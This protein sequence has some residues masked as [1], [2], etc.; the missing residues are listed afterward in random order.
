MLAKEGGLPDVS[1]FVSGAFK[2]IHISVFCKSFGE[3]T[4]VND[5][6]WKV[7]GN[8]LFLWTACI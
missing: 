8:G 2:V 7:K 6:V 1:N 3:S 4:C 5:V